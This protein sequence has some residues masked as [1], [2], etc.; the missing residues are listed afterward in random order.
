MTTPDPRI[1]SYPAVV[2]VEKLDEIIAEL[3]AMRLANAVFIPDICTCWWCRLVRKL[4][5]L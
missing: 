2:T 4:R 3:R 5:H 1:N